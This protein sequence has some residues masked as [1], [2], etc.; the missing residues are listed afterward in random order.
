MV[1]IVIPNMKGTPRDEATGVTASWKRVGKLKRTGKVP[2]KMGLYIHK[3]VTAQIGFTTPPGAK[4]PRIKVEYDPATNRMRMSRAVSDTDHAFV[5]TIKDGT[6]AFY[7][8]LDH[9]TV[10][11]TYPARAIPF[12]VEGGYLVLS[13][14]DWAKHTGV[15]AARDARDAV[16]ARMGAA[17]KGRAA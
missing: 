8:P 5:P 14:P 1:W 12:E 15:M 16:L 2:M 10:T 17:P 9:V 13:L 6:L 11:D 3:H 4:A 7:I